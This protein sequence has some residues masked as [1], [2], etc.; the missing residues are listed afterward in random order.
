MDGFFH[1]PGEVRARALRARFNE[2]GSAYPGRVAPVGWDVRSLLPA[3]AGLA[4]QPV[5]PI[6]ME[7]R[8]S[9]VTLR[10]QQLAPQ[11]T[12]PH[13]DDAELAGV[14]YL[15][16][17]WQCRGGTA[18]YR[19]R[20]S[21]LDR[22]PERVDLSLA[23]RMARRGLRTAE[24]LRRWLT[25]PAEDARGFI[26]GSTPDWEQIGLVAMRWNRLVLY[27]GRLFHSGQVCDG[28]F[29]EAPAGRRLTL[30]LFFHLRPRARA[31][32]RR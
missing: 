20:E 28:D 31:P 22:W 17:P 13:C 29:G 16:L 14:V 11:Q 8:Y 9:M 1:D 30:N 7:A 2:A 32:A 12:G 3:L 4:G 21:G 23:L 6:A 24:E 26:A 15:N 27:D 10:E 25:E 18:F 5:D 19:H